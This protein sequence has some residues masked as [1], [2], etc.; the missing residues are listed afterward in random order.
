MFCVIAEINMTPTMWTI[1]TNVIQIKEEDKLTNIFLLL[2]SKGEI[3]DSL[4]IL[5]PKKRKEKVICPRFRR[6]K[7]PFSYSQSH[8][9]GKSLW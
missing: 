2:L 7:T 9:R 1:V 3:A 4:N 8:L 6:S 5:F